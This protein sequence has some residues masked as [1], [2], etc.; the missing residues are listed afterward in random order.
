MSTP[1]VVKPGTPLTAV[2]VEVFL[3]GV[4]VDA[5]AITYEIRDPGGAVANDEDGIAVSGYAGRKV[6]T[7]RYDAG[8][9]VLPQTAAAGTYTITWT[10]TRP[11]QPAITRAKTFVVETGQVEDAA[12][13]G[14]SR[15]DIPDTANI[16]TLRSLM[17]DVN[18]DETRWAF[19]NSEL[20]DYVEKAITVHTAG[21][22]TEAS[23]TPDDIAMSMFLA[24]CSGYEALASNS[25]RRF[26]WQDGNESVDKS[27][28]ANQLIAL[29]KA[30]MDKYDKIRKQRADEL[31]AGTTPT[32]PA[33]D[34]A[35]FIP[36]RARRLR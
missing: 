21:A 6:G 4:L 3:A 17:K 32:D 18:P 5:T 9:V 15:R 14:T 1:P 25:S 35:V 11:S 2:D 22:R 33:R 36:R 7:G 30:L 10:I 8:A 29:C 26:R 24:Q 28:Q 16:N 31:Q 12:K 27:M 13:D 19:F 23:A 34:L 20:Q